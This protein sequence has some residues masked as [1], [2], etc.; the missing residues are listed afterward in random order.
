[1]A[2]PDL[3]KQSSG[4]AALGVAAS[5]D[6]TMIVAATN[7]F[8]PAGTRCLE[9]LRIDSSSIA[10]H[11]YRERAPVD[12]FRPQ[13]E[14]LERERLMLVTD[15]VVV[16]TELGMFYADSIASRL[17]R[18]QVQA[19]RMEPRSTCRQTMSAGKTRMH[20]CTYDI[21]TTRL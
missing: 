1:M 4:R 12:D 8:W 11:V 3:S 17:A 16:P 2:T 20:T 7:K 6:L 18:R 21:M 10:R 5:H 14:A 15:E 13:F 19:L 9:A